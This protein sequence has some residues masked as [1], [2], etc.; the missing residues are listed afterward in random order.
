MVNFASLILCLILWC[1]LTGAI[2]QSSENGR[3]QRSLLNQAGTCLEQSE[4]TEN[5]IIRTKD[6]RALGAR[7]LNETSLG[8]NS[9]EQCLRL[10]CSFHGCNVAVYEEKDGGNCYLFDC[11]RADDFRCKFTSHSHYSS[12]IIRENAHEEELAQLKKINPHTTPPTPMTHSTT[13]TATTTTSTAKPA[14]SCSRYQF[15]CRTSGECIAIYNACDGIPQCADGSDEAAELG[16][17]ATTT[18]A[19]TTTKWPVTTHATVVSKSVIFPDMKSNANDW[20]P[21]H[22]RYAARDFDNGANNA[23][24]KT[25]EGSRTY[26]ERRPYQPPNG[27]AYPEMDRPAN[28]YYNSDPNHHYGAAWPERNADYRAG[29]S[30]DR[31]YDKESHVPYDPAANSGSI[32][33]NGKHAEWDSN[34]SINPSNENRRVAVEHPA[35]VQ[36]IEVIESDPVIRPLDNRDQP[37]HADHPPH[38]QEFEKVTDAPVVVVSTTKAAPVLVTKEKVVNNHAHVNHFHVNQAVYHEEKAEQSRQTVGAVWALTL[39][40]SVTGVLVLLVGCRLRSLKRHLRRGPRTG[41]TRDADYLVNGMY[42]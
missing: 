27:E 11:G 35:Q 12:A 13:T 20:R 19:T 17:P 1:C 4:I 10:C 8:L 29:D 5:T 26:A 3:H 15:E 31:Y 41:H 42:L 24:W 40:M 39:G 6:S 16:C 33:T 37:F 7:F 30:Y 34:H 25:P 21:S 38:I 22:D 2:S 28:H 36:H 18:E 32:H 14:R 23:R 9:R